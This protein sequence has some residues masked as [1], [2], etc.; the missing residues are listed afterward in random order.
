MVQ[1]SSCHSSFLC[2]NIALSQIGAAP[3]AWLLEWK[4]HIE[5]EQSFNW[6]LCEQK[7]TFLLLSQ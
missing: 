6:W 7:D 4:R 1:I 5:Q 2:H 3:V